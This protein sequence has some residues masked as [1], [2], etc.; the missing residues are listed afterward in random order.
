LIA[1][2]ANKVRLLS[3]ADA[4]TG[5]A[6]RHDTNTIEAHLA[7]LKDENLQNIYKILTQSIID[8]GKKL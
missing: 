3:P 7:F 8:H 1:E 2:T 5:P 4:Q 6:K